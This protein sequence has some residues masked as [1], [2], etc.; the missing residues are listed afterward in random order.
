MV[1]GCYS[2]V[3]GM[4]VNGCGVVILW[5]LGCQSM[6]AGLLFNGC[7]FVNQWLLGY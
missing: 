6:V 4:L 7:W 2:A 3:A 5:L 1:A